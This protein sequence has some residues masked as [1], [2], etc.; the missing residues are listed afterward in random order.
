M[1]LLHFAVLSLAL[2]GANTLA[3]RYATS[4]WAKLALMVACVACASILLI[5]ERS[6][7]P[8]GDDS[9]LRLNR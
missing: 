3:D 8:L 7:K 4:N 2:V 9:G 5:H 6:A 1:G